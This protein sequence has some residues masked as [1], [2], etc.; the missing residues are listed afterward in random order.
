MANVLSVNLIIA[1]D[2]GVDVHAAIDY[3]AEG[4]Q[5]AAEA[6][7]GDRGSSYAIMGTGYNDPNEIGH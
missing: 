5:L 3:I 2:E 4:A 1:L 7:E 6:M